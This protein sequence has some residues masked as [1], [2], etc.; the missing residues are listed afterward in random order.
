MTNKRPSC[1]IAPVIQSGVNSM[2][3][4]IAILKAYSPPEYDEYG[5]PVSSV[6]GRTV[7]VQPRSIYASEFY[8]AAQVGLKPSLGLYLAHRDDYNGE[9]VIEYAGR[10]YSVI[11]ADWKAQ[12]DGLLLVCEEKTQNE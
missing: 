1:R 7:Y 6:E 11:R 5:N 2:Y 10:E 8:Q 12:R 9:K 4:D 3:D